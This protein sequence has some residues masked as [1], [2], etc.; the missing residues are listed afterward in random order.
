MWRS[1]PFTS[2]LGGQRQ[3]DI[4]EFKANLI[5]I[6]FQD[7]HCFVM[8]GNYDAKRRRCLV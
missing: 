8:V 7:N 5:Y 1:T 4:C 6:E 3:A 2:A